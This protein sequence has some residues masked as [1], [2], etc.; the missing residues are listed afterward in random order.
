MQKIAVQRAVY[1]ITSG[2]I[3]LLV[4]VALCILQILFTH[5]VL[6]SNHWS[7]PNDLL[8][9]G[10]ITASAVTVPAVLAMAAGCTQS[11]K[12]LTVSLVLYVCSLI[13]CLA[14]AA[15]GFVQYEEFRE[16]Q[17]SIFT[18]AAIDL[19][20]GVLCLVHMA[21]ACADLCYCCAVKNT[22]SVPNLQSSV[23]Q[24]PLPRDSQQL[25]SLPFLGYVK[26][27]QQKIPGKNPMVSN[28]ITTHHQPFGG[29]VI[30]GYQHH[31]NPTVSS[32]SSTEAT[33]PPPYEM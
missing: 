20:A 1:H 21:V 25:G 11:R 8:P 22:S 13:I 9:T 6:S 17:L 2:L 5:D 29:V 32:K 26:T 18:L 30:P 15:S 33:A 3:C 24:Q 23:T 12:C 7:W 28:T 10:Y 27:Q 4:G 31:L 19:G 14:V 16:G